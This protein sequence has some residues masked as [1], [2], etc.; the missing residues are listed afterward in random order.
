MEEER[1]K[2]LRELHAD[3]DSERRRFE[4]RKPALIEEVQ[5][6]A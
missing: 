5:G 1:E 4:E 6:A 3:L 2:L